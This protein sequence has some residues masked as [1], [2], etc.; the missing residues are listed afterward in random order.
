MKKKFENPELV[1]Y[2]FEENIDT[3]GDSGI[4]GTG[5]DPDSVVEG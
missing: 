3:I 1:I 2:F 5:D 4:D